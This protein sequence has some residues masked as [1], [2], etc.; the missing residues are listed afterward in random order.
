MI[1]PLTFRNDASDSHPDRCDFGWACLAIGSGVAGLLIPELGLAQAIVADGGSSTIVST[2]ATG[3]IAVSIAPANSA[4]IS[5]N[6]YTAFSV[7]VSGVNLDNRGVSAKTILNE[8]TSTNVSEVQGT[9]SVV[10]DKAD[11]ILANPNGITVNGG[12]FVNTGN[13]ALTTG[14]IGSDALGNVTSTVSAGHISIEGMGLSG[15]MEELALV[16]KTLSIGG[17]VASDIV[18]P[19]SHFN[20]IAGDS[21]TSFD[22]DRGGLGV[23]GAGVIPWAFSSGGG[24]ESN[25]IVV[26]ITE[27]GSIASGR[28]SVTVTDRGAGVRFAGNQIASVGGFR[29]N[30]SGKLLVDGAGITSKGSVNATVGSVALT[31][32][33]GG[34]AKIESQQSG[35]VIRA[36][37]G[38]IDL[39]QG[40]LAGATV[41]SDNFDSSGGVTL[42]AEG[43]I[44]AEQVGTRR[45]QLVSE[46][47]DLPNSR[48]NS[49][50]VLTANGG[51]R[52]DGVDVSTTDDLQLTSNGEIHLTNAIGEL[53]GDLRLFSNDKVSFDATVIT[54][55]GAV[56]VEGTALRFG[57]DIL[58]QSRTELKAAEGG[59]YARSTTGS[60]YNFGSLLQGKAGANV[61][62]VAPSGATITSAGVFQNKSLSVG[63]LAVVFGE[64]DDLRISAAGDVLNETGRLFSNAAISIAAGG[65]IVNQ[66]AFTTAAS[67]Y[68]VTTINGGRFASSLFLKRKRTTTVAADYGAES[69]NGELSYIFGSGD[70]SL[71][72][73]NIYSY[74]A[75]ITGG[76]VEID[77]ADTF[78]NTS[79]QVG[80][81][82]FTQSCKWFCKVSGF[83]NLRSIGGGV[84]ASNELRISAGSKVTNLAGRLEGVEGVTVTTPLTEFTPRFSTSLIESPSG[85]TGFFRGSRGYLSTS[86]QY[87]TIRALDGAVTI[88]GDADFGGAEVVSG[89]DLTISGTRIQ[90]QT[91]QTSSP[92]E[93]RPLGFLWNFF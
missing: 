91:P 62:T 1:F 3:P 5:H 8:V 57:A 78:T 32:T 45:A 51:L 65:D 26:D 27:T 48:D 11:V 49:H 25:G 74:G 37:A 93:R 50:V 87:G 34:R 30:S 76:N 56:R 12:R 36:T 10:G 70:V 86:Y 13:V 2:P 4:S 89:S 7:P 29:L 44:V 18:G 79:R 55:Q 9:L 16:S 33:D 66:T 47:G 80:E 20:V 24:S 54:A 69:I 38:D 41:S 81:F 77:A 21:S 73:E 59:F 42:I 71:R 58:E 82:R 22:R 46:I 15:T 83:S 17:A 43:D 75:D 28:I 63:R 64:V 88:D 40:R 90:S 23:N 85:L 19:L 31:S 35:V 39:G 72:A 61:G 68:Q 60:I 53:G 84:T 92:F 14:R 67:P 6:T 52:L